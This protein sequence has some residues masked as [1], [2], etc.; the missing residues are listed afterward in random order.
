MILIRFP[1]TDA[2]RSALTQLADRFNFKSLASGEMLVPE[3][4]LA[5]LAAQGIPFTSEGPTNLMEV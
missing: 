5:F 4:S 3:V 1:N 2:K